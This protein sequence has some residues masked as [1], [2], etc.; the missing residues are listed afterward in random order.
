MNPQE[1]AP[2]VIL[3]C[4]SIKPLLRFGGSF[5]RIGIKF[6][7]N[8]KMIVIHL[9]LTVYVENSI[10]NSICVAQILIFA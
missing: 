9:I 3:Q 8:S 7:N 4:G 1:T 10:T 5:F 6:K 2:W